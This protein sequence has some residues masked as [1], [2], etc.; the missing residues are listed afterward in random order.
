MNAFLG[1]IPADVRTLAAEFNAKASEIESLI[2]EI[3]T[4]FQATTWRGQD[5]EDFEGS[6]NGEMTN[7][8]NQL[9]GALRDA[10]TI[11]ENNASQQEVA[12]S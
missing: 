3:T 7:T 6:W 10:G 8:L 5:R 1:Q 9:A 2:S 4:R 12:S 11:A